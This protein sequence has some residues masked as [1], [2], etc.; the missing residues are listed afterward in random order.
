MVVVNARC[1]DG[2]EL[3]SLP[4]KHFDGRSL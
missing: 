3:S 4:V 1:L 2:I